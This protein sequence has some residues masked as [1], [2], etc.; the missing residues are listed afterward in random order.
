MEGR[1]EDRCLWG[2]AKAALHRA[3]PV[4]IT[5]EKFQRLIVRAGVNVTTVA[6]V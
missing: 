2:S 3:R 5:G 1:A 4:G 6:A